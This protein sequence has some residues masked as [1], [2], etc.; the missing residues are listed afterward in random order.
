[1]IAVSPSTG[2]PTGTVSFYQNGALLTTVAVAS[3]GTAAMGTSYGIKGTFSITAT[4]S[5]AVPA[6]YANSST[7]STLSQVIQ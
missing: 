5:S 1:V 6:N 3:K 2:I 4:Y 7:T